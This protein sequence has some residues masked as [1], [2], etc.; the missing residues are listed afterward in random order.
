M[1]ILPPWHSTRGN[2]LLQGRVKRVNIEKRICKRKRMIQQSQGQ[3]LGENY[4]R[5]EAKKQR[6]D[7]DM[8][9]IAR[10]YSRGEATVATLNSEVQRAG[11]SMVARTQG[12]DKE[13]VAGSLPQ[14]HEEVGKREVAVIPQNLLV[15]Q[16][17]KRHCSDTSIK[18]KKPRLNKSIYSGEY[19]QPLAQSRRQKGLAI[20]T[21]VDDVK[22]DTGEPLASKEPSHVCIDVEKKLQNPTLSSH[23]CG[24]DRLSLQN[25]DTLQS[26]D[27]QQQS[28]AIKGSAPVRSNIVI[29][30]QE[31]LPAWSGEENLNLERNEPAPSENQ[32][33]ELQ[34]NKQTPGVN[35]NDGEEIAVDQNQDVASESL[36]VGVSEHQQVEIKESSKQTPCVNENAVGEIPVVQSQAVAS[37]SFN[38]VA[39]EHQQVEPEESSKKTPGV[40]ESD[41]GESVVDPREAISTETIN[42]GTSDAQQFEIEKCN[43]TTVVNGSDIGESGVDQGEVVASGSI[44]AVTSKHQQLEIEGIKQTTGL[45]EID[46]KE[47]VDQNQAIASESFDVVSSE[48][49]HPEIEADNQTTG[50]NESDVGE[51]VVVQWRA[52]A[53]QGVTVVTVEHRQLEKKANNQS[54]GVN[55][56][57]SGEIVV[58]QGEAVASGSV[59][60]VTSKHQDFSQG[61]LVGLDE[62]SGQVRDT[63]MS[64]SLLHENRRIQAD[65]CT[66]TAVM[67]DVGIDAVRDSESATCSNYARTSGLKH[68][69]TEMWKKFKFSIRHLKG[70][71]DFVCGVD[72]RNSVL[73]SGG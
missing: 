6:T 12:T 22:N 72:C 60:V 4:S 8:T 56:S 66:R 34:A 37:E 46:V 30:T 50:V 23:T 65:K 61:Q 49:Q 25:K 43:Q 36:N 58:H 17:Y 63:P 19:L 38:V 20:R 62:E 24:E 53:S 55:K 18:A 14:S 52:V 1:V 33:V 48:H 71:T 57:G 68:R 29:Q 47:I 15:D 5:T 10:R 51:I 13:M 69:K 59:N 26:G 45:N 7:G 16:S 73:A 11:S 2:Y 9:S 44:N 70:H 32:Q 35:D 67:T 64:R 40:N 3:S 42:V 31:M 28:A 41:V 54:F 27:E 21:E 39:S